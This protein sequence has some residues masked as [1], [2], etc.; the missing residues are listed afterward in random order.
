MGGK[1]RRYFLFD[2]SNQKRMICS[3]TGTKLD[4]IFYDFKNGLFLGLLVYVVASERG[5]INK[6]KR[7]F[8]L[9]QCTS[10]NPGPKMYQLF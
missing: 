6:F 10:G 5:Q 1:V 3:E 8:I 7:L 2:V 4:L 9:K